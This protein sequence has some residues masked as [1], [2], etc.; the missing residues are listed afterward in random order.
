MPDYK[1]MYTTLFNKITDVIEQLQEVQRETEEMYI[2]SPEPELI[3]IE[4]ETDDKP[5]E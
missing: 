1:K 2:E 3:V 5:E 4:P